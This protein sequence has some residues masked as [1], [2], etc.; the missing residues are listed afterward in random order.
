VSEQAPLLRS[1]DWLTQAALLDAACLKMQI[2]TPKGEPDYQ[3]LARACGVSS[4]TMAGLL[5][6]TQRPSRASVETLARYA[7]QPLGAWL[8]A[9]GFA[10]ELPDKPS[11]GGRS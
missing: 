10:G 8:R 4:A 5:Q 11:R 2:V 6:H 3:R 9:A 7:E 1:P